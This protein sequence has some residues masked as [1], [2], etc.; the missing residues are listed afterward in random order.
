MVVWRAETATALQGLRGV[1]GSLSPTERGPLAFLSAYLVL[2]ESLASFQG[3]ALLNDTI[4]VRPRPHCIVNPS[5][6]ES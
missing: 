4:Q 5:Y 1:L 3:S 6:V 2:N